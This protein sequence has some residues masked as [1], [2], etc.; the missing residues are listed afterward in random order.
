MIDRDKALELPTRKR[1]YDEINRSPGIHFRE[2]K[3][4]T[5]LA[6][7]ELQY[8]L[9][10]LD[11]VHLVRLQKRGKFIRYFPLVGEHTE[12]EKLT[13]GLLREESVRKIILLLIEKKRATNRQ[14]SMFLELAPSTVSFHMQKLLKSGLVEKKRTPKKTYFHLVNPKEAKRLLTTYRKSFF[15]ELV[16]SFVEVWEGIPPEK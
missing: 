8:H 10:V 6:I 13:L 3:R 16:D 15:D 9:D 14:L 5:G 1:L 7:G 12:S 11:K 4:R 2:L